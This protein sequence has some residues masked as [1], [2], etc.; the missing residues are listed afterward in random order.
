MCGL[1]FRAGLSKSK[2]P[3]RF[4]KRSCMKMTCSIHNSAPGKIGFLEYLFSS[5]ITKKEK[6]KN[7][8]KNKNKRGFP[9]G[10]KGQYDRPVADIWQLESMESAQCEA[11]PL[12]FLLFPLSLLELALHLI[13]S[14]VLAH[15]PKST[16]FTL[17][18][19]PDRREISWLPC[20]EL[21][22]VE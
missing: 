14:Q 19:C 17:H 4:K 8:N 13:V 18:S 12:L 5:V 2:R 16:R 6:N 3:Q 9:A 7:K 20:C 1:G 15:F 22:L 21:A 11:L 10:L